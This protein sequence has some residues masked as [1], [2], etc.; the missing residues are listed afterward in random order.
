MESALELLYKTLDD[1][2]KDDLKRFRSLLKEDGRI[3]AGKLENAGVTDIVNMMVECYGPEEA[4][5]ITLKILRKMNQNQLA[6]ELQEKHEEGNKGKNTDHRKR[7]STDSE[8][9]VYQEAAMS[10]I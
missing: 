7:G 3:G 4:V 2:E 8:K 1:L 10:T 5:K 6:K 9:G